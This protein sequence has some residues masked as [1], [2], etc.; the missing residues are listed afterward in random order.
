MFCAARERLDYSVLKKGG[1]RVGWILP[2]HLSVSHLARRR[3]WTMENRPY[4]LQYPLLSSER[5]NVVKN[6]F[7]YTEIASRF[8]QLTGSTGARAARPRAGGPVELLGARIDSLAGSCQAALERPLGGSPCTRTLSTKTT[9][10]PSRLRLPPFAR[11]G[12]RKHDQYQ[13]STV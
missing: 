2:R 1:S 12:A 11:A 13:L 5:I 4:R 9:D 7:K 6:V 10:S 3:E 8:S